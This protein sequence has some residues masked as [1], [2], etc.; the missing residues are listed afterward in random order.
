MSISR[1]PA[2]GEFVRSFNRI[3][4]HR[5]RYEVFRDFVTMAAIAMHNAIHKITSLEDEY[6]RIVKCYERDQVSEFFGLFSKLVMLLDAEP[7]DVLGP[8]YMELELGN[9]QAGQFFTPHELSELLARMT[10]GDELKTLNKPFITL[11]EPACGAGGM[12]LA[13]VKVMIS[14]G[15]DPAK[16]LWVQCQDVDRTAALMCYLQLSL[17][18][19]PARVIVGNTLSAETREVFYTPAHYLG[20]WEYRLRRRD[21]EEVTAQ[22]MVIP[23]AQGVMTEPIVPVVHVETQKQLISMVRSGAVSTQAQYDFGF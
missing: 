9:T 23:D 22:E 11:S 7:Q 5:H 2:W 14:H 3:A 21:D 16:R 13:F 8:L 17:W 15:H 18:N 4:A 10:Y 1:T 20:H 6:L 19:I 12:V